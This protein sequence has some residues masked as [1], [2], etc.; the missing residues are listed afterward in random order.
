LSCNVTAEAVPDNLLNSD[1]F[2]AT[3]FKA[4]K[5][6]RVSL[7]GTNEYRPDNNERSDFLDKFETGAYIPSVY[8]YN[9]SHMLGDSFSAAGA[10]FQVLNVRAGDSIL[11]Y[12]Q[13]MAKWPSLARMGCDVSVIDIDERYL[14]I[15]EQQAQAISVNINTV[16]G[17]FGDGVP[18]KNSIAFC[19]TK[20]STTASTTQD[21]CVSYAPSLNRP[22]ACSSQ[23]TD[24]L[25]QKL[26]AQNRAIRL[27][28][29]SRWPVPTG[30][31]FARLV[32]ARVPTRVLH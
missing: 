25:T 16:R 29:A 26:L 9:D 30:N 12:G 2:S 19:S 1:P 15:I 22:A 6:F 20:H 10:I 28:T 3:Y 11:D 23:E 13:A 18:G 21:C 17:R 27:G 14:R 4:C 31:S 8:R 7:I 5:D 24:H 32:R